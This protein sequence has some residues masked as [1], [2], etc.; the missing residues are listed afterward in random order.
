M[1]TWRQFGGTLLLVLMGAPAGAAVTPVVPFVDCV[2]LDPN[3]GAMTA[4]FSYANNDSN[5]NAVSLGANNFFS[6]AP[7][8][9]GQ[10]SVF[11]PGVQRRVFHVTDAINVTLTWTLN[12]VAASASTSQPGIA[13]FGDRIFQHGFQAPL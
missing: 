6:P 9:R 4:Y 12:G 8:N 2:D 10:P 5:P 7:S 11:Q 1:I 13:C 3:D